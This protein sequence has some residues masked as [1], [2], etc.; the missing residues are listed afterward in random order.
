ML[1]N[2]CKPTG[3]G[4]LINKIMV[5]K[6]FGREKVIRLVRDFSFSEQAE[7]HCIEITGDI[8][9]LI[10]VLKILTIFSQSVLLKHLLM[11]KKEKCMEQTYKHIYAKTVEKKGPLPVLN[12][13]RVARM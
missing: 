10:N 11:Y 1:N 9:L 5:P 6:A 4:T 3:I 7:R 13:D 12:P 2:K 8:W